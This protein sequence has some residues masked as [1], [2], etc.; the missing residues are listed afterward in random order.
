LHFQELVAQVN[1]PVYALGGMMDS[2][3]TSV[4]ECGG[5]G[6]AGMGAFLA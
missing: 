5:Q 6:V 3:L 4:Y 1:L 2:D